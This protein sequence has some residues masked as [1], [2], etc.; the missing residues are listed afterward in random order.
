MKYLLYPVWRIIVC[1]CALVNWICT[2]LAW[3]IVL[4]WTLKTPT[5]FQKKDF[6]FGINTF[7]LSVLYDTPELK[8]YTNP[9]HAL[10][11]RVTR[12]KNPDYDPQFYVRQF[13]G[14]QK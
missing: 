8:Y 3:I 11:G 9:L 6:W 7:D 5:N 12:V 10:I 1:I 14:L 2:A 4:I 13:G